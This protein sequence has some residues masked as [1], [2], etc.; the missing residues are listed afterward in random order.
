MIA[1][2]EIADAR[3]P[4]GYTLLCKQEAIPLTALGLLLQGPRTSD[5][6]RS[7]RAS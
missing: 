3:G 4:L 1:M 5:H 7:I 2:S 6:D